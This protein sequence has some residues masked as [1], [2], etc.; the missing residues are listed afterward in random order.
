MGTGKQGT[1]KLSHLLIDL[2][3][4]S[5][6]GSTEYKDMQPKMVDLGVPRTF[7]TNMGV[8]VVFDEC[9]CPWTALVSGL[10][11]G[12]EA[13]VADLENR[14][15][16][17]KRGAHVPHSNDGGHFMRHIETLMLRAR[18]AG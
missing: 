18:L 1:Q 4:F 8:I 11:R 16:P 17:L 10:P 12:V 13:T 9:G 15:G 2:A 7:D 6:F 5:A 14:S 3:F